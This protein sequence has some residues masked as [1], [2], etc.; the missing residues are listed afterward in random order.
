[1]VGSRLCHEL[2][3]PTKCP[4]SCLTKFALYGHIQVSILHNYI[5]IGERLVH[6]NSMHLLHSMQNATKPSE[7]ETKGQ[8]RIRKQLE[9]VGIAPAVDNGV[10]PVVRYASL[11]DLC[12]LGGLF[13][14]MGRIF[15]FL[16]ANG[17][18]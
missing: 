17:G 6:C 16:F 2:N 5:S 7:D 18:F 12:Q 10:E 9:R 8:E 13:R 15:I 14:Q 3:D 4:C 1:M 11:L